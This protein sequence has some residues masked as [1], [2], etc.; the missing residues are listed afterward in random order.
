MIP[1][2]TARVPLCTQPYLNDE[3]LRKT[4]RNVEQVAHASPQTIERRLAQLDEEWDIDRVMEA[5]TAADDGDMVAAWL[6][7]EG[8]ATLKKIYREGE[9]VRL[10]PANATMQPIYTERENVEVQGRVLARIGQ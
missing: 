8:E 7:R 3:L 9:K 6:K 2:T 5:T 1:T 4:H 10:Q